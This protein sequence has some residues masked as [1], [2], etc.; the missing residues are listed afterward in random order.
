MRGSRRG[1]SGSSVALVSSGPPVADLRLLLLLWLLPLSPRAGRQPTRSGPP[2]SRPW[3]GDSRQP[4]H[5]L[6]PH[7]LQR[8]SAAPSWGFPAGAGESRLLPPAPERR[9]HP[10]RPPRKERT[11]TRGGTVPRLSG[12]VGPG[13]GGVRHDLERMRGL[14]LECC[15]Q[16]RQTGERERGH[17]PSSEI[18]ARPPPTLGKHTSGRGKRAE[19]RARRLRGSR[20][21]SLCLPALEDPGSKDD[22]RNRTLAPPSLHPR[23]SEFTLLSP[24]RPSQWLHERVHGLPQGIWA[25]G[26]RLSPSSQPS[27]ALARPRGWE[28]CSVW[29][30]RE[31]PVTTRK[32]SDKQK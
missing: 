6:S 14:I 20:T 16:T 13:A 31:N 3:E 21:G 30:L 1:A 18:R 9:Q 23:L 29:G 19:A 8:A 12:W 27:L 2:S 32:N 11:V 7:W 5:L 28:H 10:A 4:A 17:T 15:P 26:H 22:A 25:S 24:N